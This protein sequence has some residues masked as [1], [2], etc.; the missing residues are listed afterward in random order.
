MKVLEKSV[1]N[2]KLTKLSS[3]RKPLPIR[4][5]NPHCCDAMVVTS[6]QLVMECSFYSRSYSHSFIHPL[7]LSSNP[8]NPILPYRRTIF[9]HQQLFLQQVNNLTKRLRWQSNK[10]KNTEN[11]SSIVLNIYDP[12]LCFHYLNCLHLRLLLLPIHVIYIS[13]VF[14]VHVFV[15]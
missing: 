4:K 6:Q 5:R 12:C 11:V 9:Y 2:L 7:A 10:K 3:I 13:N 8:P 15:E 1:N 14:G